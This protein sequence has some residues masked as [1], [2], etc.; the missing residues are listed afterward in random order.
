MGVALKTM[1]G[2]K[3][4]LALTELKHTNARHIL[5]DFSLDFQLLTVLWT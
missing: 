3:C 1:E 2:D 5:H 4:E